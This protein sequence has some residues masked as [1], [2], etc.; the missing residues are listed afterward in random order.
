MIKNGIAEKRA[1]AA[2][3]PDQ[4]AAAAEVEDSDGDDD[5]DDGAE[6]LAALVQLIAM[7]RELSQ[8]LITEAEALAAQI[9]A[10]AGDDSAP[11]S[12]DSEPDD[13]DPPASKFAAPPPARAEPAP[14]PALVKA[15]GETAALRKRLDAMAPDLAAL[16][17]RLAAL[18]AQPLP[19]KAALR[20]VSKQ[21]D[22]MGA[23]GPAPVRGGDK[24]SLA[25]L[26][27][28]ER[29]HALMK[30]SLAN[31]VGPRF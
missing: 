5:A 27:T 22:G 20:A 21:A 4:D 17:S 19:A 28:H 6:R 12:D 13:D 16:S 8:K 9:G 1:F 7:A 10:G 26:S 15:L 25:A 2:P 14:S 23:D 18:E 29:A 31:P 24:V 11:A 3:A 30:I